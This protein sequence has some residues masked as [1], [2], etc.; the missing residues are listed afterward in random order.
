MPFVNQALILKQD[1]NL[2]A[3]DNRQDLNTVER[4]G[5]NLYNLRSL[6]AGKGYSLIRYGMP[7]DRH[8]DYP[9]A[10]VVEI[11]QKRFKPNERSE[12]DRGFPSI[13]Q[14]QLDDLIPLNVDDDETPGQG[15]KG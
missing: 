12:V 13:P 3:V 5:L 9:A 14:S 1:G 2:F 8:L 4:K 10:Q 15:E 6:L 11:W 7:D